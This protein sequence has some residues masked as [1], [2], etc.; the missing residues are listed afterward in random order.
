ML[1]NFLHQT[2]GA[3]RE[4]GLAIGNV[5]APFSSRFPVSFPFFQTH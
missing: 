3:S 2:T 5:S 1:Y 4:L